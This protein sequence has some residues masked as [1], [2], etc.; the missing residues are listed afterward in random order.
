MTKAIS[1]KGELT[2]TEQT[3]DIASTKALAEFATT[4]K[5]FIIKEKLFTEIQGKNYVEVEGWQFCGA[6]TGILPVMKEVIDLS[7]SNEIK[8]K[9]VVEL[10]R[11]KDGEVVGAGVA[12]CSSK[13]SKRKTSDEYVI[14]SMAQTRATGKAY[15]NTF[16][17]LM[18]IAGYEATPADEVRDLPIEH[19]PTE[20]EV[21]NQLPIEDVVAA[22]K[23]KLDVL[24]THDRLR[25]LKITRKLNEKSLNER[26]WRFLYQEIVLKEFDGGKET[27][28]EA[29]SLPSPSDS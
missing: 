1:N 20:A 28:A 29:K 3:V 16:G 12:I 5:A 24:P 13:E 25:A 22:V 18:K 14:A 21:I 26:D 27:D 19:E 2:L 10:K 4:L 7:D 15:R 11:M 8:Y 6:A 9:A 23:A 17:W